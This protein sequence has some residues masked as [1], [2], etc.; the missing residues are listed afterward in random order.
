MIVKCAPQ[1]GE[2]YSIEG[3]LRSSPPLSLQLPPLSL[4]LSHTH[5]LPTTRSLSLS[6]SLQRHDKRML[7]RPG[8]SRVTRDR[9]C[10][11]VALVQRRAHLINHA[12]GHSDIR[13][14]VIVSSA[15]T[16]C[17]RRERVKSPRICRDRHP[18]LG[19][20]SGGLSLLACFP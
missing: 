3:P 11:H 17:S 13:V 4:S 15:R 7:G 19:W 18:W 5:T 1:Q 12:R 2:T 9:T 16:R 8:R 6:L 10:R 14:P 20:D